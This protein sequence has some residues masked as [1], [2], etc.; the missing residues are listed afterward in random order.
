MNLSQLRVFPHHSSTQAYVV[1][2]S[3][4]GK[5]LPK[6]RYVIR[7]LVPS[8]YI[9]PLSSMP[10]RLRV[11]HL[12]THSAGAVVVALR[13]RFNGGISSTS[14]CQR[15][16]YKPVTHPESSGMYQRSLGSTRRCIRTSELVQRC[17][18]VCLRQYWNRIWKDCHSTSGGRQTGKSMPH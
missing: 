9:I 14:R 6:L 12:S 8:P 16:G 11:L 17:I 1:K 5:P 13:F 18:L 2:R 3:L 15:Q 7:P 4:H 10:A